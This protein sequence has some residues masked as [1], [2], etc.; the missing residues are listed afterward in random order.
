MTLKGEGVQTRV[1]WGHNPCYNKNPNSSTSYQQHCRYFI[2]KKGDLT[3]PQTK[4]R[5]HL[6]AQLTK[7]HEEGNCLIV[8]LN[9]NEHIY[10]KS[11]G[12]ALTDID[13][14]AMREVVGGFTRQPVGPTYFRGS[15]PINGVWATSDISICNAAIMPASYG[16]GDHRLFVINFSVADMIG[17]S[18]QKVACPMSQQLN[19]KIPWVAAAYAKILEGKELSR[20][21]IECMGAVHRK[22]KSRALA[23]QRL[24]KLDKEL[25]QYMRY[26]EKKC[27]KI[28]SGWIPFSPEAPL[29][30]R[31]TQVYRSLLR[32]HAGG[33][34]NQCNLKQVA[35]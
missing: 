21:L 27:C 15:K 34:K 16:I 6:V 22:C 8:C 4:F 28:K 30:I 7:W 25:G 3:C 18:H 12:K 31:W 10:K 20:R 1:V 23:R 17:I 33:I 26:D 11:I 35:R 2:T 5:E 14:L 19:T 24:N 13:G 32:L 29:W 9:A